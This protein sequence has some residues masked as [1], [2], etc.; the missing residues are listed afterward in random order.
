MKKLWSFTV[1]YNEPWSKE[2]LPSNVCIAFTNPEMIRRI[3]E[4]RDLA[5]RVIGRCVEAL[6]VKNITAD[7]KSRNVPV[8]NDKLKLGCLTVILGTKSDDVKLLLKHPG[9]IE[10]TKM[11]FLALDNFHYFALETVPM[12]VLDVVQETFGILA[13]ALPPEWSV[14]MML[15]QADTLMNASDGQSAPALQTPSSELA[16]QGPLLSRSKK[17][18]GPLYMCG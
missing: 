2:H 8:S 9:A 7:I 15:D 10:F 5:V 16:R 14:A 13:R 17:R 11:V 1:A 4:Q 18:I 6:V 12:D 3:R